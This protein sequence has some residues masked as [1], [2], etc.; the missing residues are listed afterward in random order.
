MQR[1]S[2]L[3]VYGLRTR[4]A[5]KLIEGIDLSFSRPIDKKT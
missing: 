3:G 5:H 1:E 2:V 4:P